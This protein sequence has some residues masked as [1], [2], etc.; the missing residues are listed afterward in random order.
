MCPLFRVVKMIP[1]FY[2]ACASR[3]LVWQYPAAW[4]QRILPFLNPTTPSFFFPI[5]LLSTHFD[6]SFSCPDPQEQIKRRSA[7]TRSHFLQLPFPALPSRF[8]PRGICQDALLAFFL[9]ACSSHR[10]WN[11]LLRLFPAPFFS[12][13]SYAPQGGQ[14]E[15][16]GTLKTFK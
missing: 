6:S 16:D 15:A 2:K 10:C 5:R 1:L 12:S 9:Q 14:E 13:V 3:Q 4:V 11:C 8:R 7:N